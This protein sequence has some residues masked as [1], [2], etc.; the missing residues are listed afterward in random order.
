VARSIQGSDSQIVA[1][2][3]TRGLFPLIFLST[4]AL[5]QRNEKCDNEL[6]C[7]MIFIA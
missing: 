7:L 5:E 6:I 3:G 1:M 4:Q 2:C